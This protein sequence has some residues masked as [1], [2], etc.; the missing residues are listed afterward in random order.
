MTS[1]DAGGPAMGVCDQLDTL[2]TDVGCVRHEHEDSHVRGG[3]A[4]VGTDLQ[5]AARRRSG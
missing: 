4:L 2:A 3:S 1:P 5:A